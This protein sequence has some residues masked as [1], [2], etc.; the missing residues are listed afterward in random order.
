GTETADASGCCKICK[1]K[2]VCKV[3]SKRTIIKVNNCISAEPVNVTSCAGHCR[4]SSMYS[5]AANMMMHHCECCHEAKTSMK[6]V[7][8]TC[9]DGSKVQHSYTHVE[10]CRCRQEGCAASTTTKPQRRRGR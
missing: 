1:P 6:Q 8:L 10:N 5:A 9:A 2:S 4:S 3:D 7:Q